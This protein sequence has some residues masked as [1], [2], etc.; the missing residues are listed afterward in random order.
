[1]VY[2]LAQFGGGLSAM[3][4]NML[5]MEFFQL[6]FPFLLGMAIIYVL[7]N[8]ALGDRIPKAPS[9]LISIIFGFF[10]ML[11]F[12]WNPYL[13]GLLVSISGMFLM[14][15]SAILLLIVVLALLGFKINDEKTWSGKGVV[16][17]IIVVFIAVILILGA[18]PL[19]GTSSVLFNSDIWTIIFFIVIIGIILYVLGREGKKAAAPAST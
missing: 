11:F 16:V 8:W 7:I 18:F 15:A 3:L 12:L 1:M 6:L 4:N 10:I 5:N 19:G 14:I 17:A 2:Y 13:Y 9:A